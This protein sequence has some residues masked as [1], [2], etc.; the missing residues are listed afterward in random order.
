LNHRPA[1]YES[2]ALTIWATSPFWNPPI[3]AVGRRLSCW[4]VR[5]SSCPGAHV[6]APVRLSPRARTGDNAG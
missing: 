2:A 6:R 1:G 3:P 4:R 5:V